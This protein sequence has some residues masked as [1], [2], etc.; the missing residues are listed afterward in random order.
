MPTHHCPRVARPPLHFAWIL[1]AVL[2]FAA[3]CGGGADTPAERVADLG[4]QNVAEPVSGLI[5]VAQPSRDQVEELLDLGYDRFI[6]LQLTEEPGTGWEEA[7]IPAAGGHFARIPVAGPDDLTRENVDALDALLAARGEE[8]TVLYCASSNRVGA[9]L[10]LRAFWLQG[11]D[12]EEAMSLGR[13]AGMRALEPAV[14]E[15]MAQ[16]G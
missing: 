8:E 12:P 7:A 16:G 5:T 4:V 13:R 14:R 10:A 9:L 15:I 1:A 6:S 2:V 11:A 3:A